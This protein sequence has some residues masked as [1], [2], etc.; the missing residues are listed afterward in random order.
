MDKKE[1]LLDGSGCGEGQGSGSSYGSRKGSGYG[2]G[3]GSGYGDDDGSGCGDAYYAYAAD[4][5]DG[6]DKMEKITKEQPEGLEYVV[7]RAASAGAFAG[8]LAG[9]DGRT[10]VLRNAR[11]L[12]YWEGAASLSE[13]ANAGVAKPDNCKFPAAVRQIKIH[14]VIEVITATDAARNS[15]ESVPVW[16][17]QR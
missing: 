1:T 4:L 10:V 13:L 9:E 16:S 2:Y 12:W 6:E 11:R 17:E 7:V 5:T 15:I 8:Y 14:G 3:Y